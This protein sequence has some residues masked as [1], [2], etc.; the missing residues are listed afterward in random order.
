MPGD[1]LFDMVERVGPGGRLIG[2][3]RVMI[4]EARRRAAQ[5]S[6]PITFKVGEANALP[7]LSSSASARAPP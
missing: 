6:L 4:A 7:R 3:D 5:R 2:L 1:D